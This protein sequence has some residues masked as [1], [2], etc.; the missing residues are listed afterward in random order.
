MIKVIFLCHGNICRS[1]MAEYVMK[2]LVRKRDLEKEFEITSGAVSDEEW[3]NPIYPP[4]QRKLREKG[5]SFGKHSAHKI[6]AGEFAAQDLV[7]VMDKSNLRWLN[8]IVGDYSSAEA[9]ASLKDS[10]IS[11]KVHM[12]MEFA[13]LDTPSVGPCKGSA[14]DVADPWYTGDFEQTYQDVLAGCNGLLEMLFPDYKSPDSKVMKIENE[15]MICSS[16]GNEWVGEEDGN[17]GFN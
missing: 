4:A 1:P 14:P 9:G 10:G 7:I 17:G 6:S 15:G 16:P 12:M 13:G 5:V 11:G 8:R 3:F 2:D